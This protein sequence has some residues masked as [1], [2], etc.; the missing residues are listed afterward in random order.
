M[1]PEIEAK[2]L[3]V[4]HEEIRH[5]LTAAGFICTAPMRLMRR[6]IIDYADRRLQTG[7]PNSYIRVRDEGD[8]VTLTYKQFDS[9]SVGG[10]R[11]VEVETSSFADTVKIFPPSV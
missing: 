8:K 9:L 1:N 10:A 6:A 2:F 7:T 3:R 11:E 4:S 5:K